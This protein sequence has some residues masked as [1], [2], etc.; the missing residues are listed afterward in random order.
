M[1]L[2]AA[3]NLF[4]TH[5]LTPT[6][7][8]WNDLR[9]GTLRSVTKA[10]ITDY[11]WNSLIAFAPFFAG[12]TTAHALNTFAHKSMP[13]KLPVRRVFSVLCTTGSFIVGAAVSYFVIRFL[14]SFNGNL[15]PFTAD[16]A[17]KL[18]MLVLVPILAI[19]PIARFF[20]VQ[21]NNN[22]YFIP[23]IVGLGAFTGYFGQ[24]SLYVIGALAALHAAVNAAFINR[25]PSYT[26]QTTRRPLTSKDLRDL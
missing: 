23:H 17:I 4:T 13:E 3:S 15:A 16:K 24:R 9:D 26:L 12:G 22:I 21:L 20:N 11:L 1:S 2:A 10:D 7:A 8:T 5:F 18:E 25:P 19:N 6:L 14:A